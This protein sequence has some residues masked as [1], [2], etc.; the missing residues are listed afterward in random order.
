MG[1][2]RYDFE[3]VEVWQGRQTFGEGLEY[4]LRTIACQIY[5]HGPSQANQSGN[6]THWCRAILTLRRPRGNDRL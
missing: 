6:A 3:G 4:R 2:H 5:R 1:T